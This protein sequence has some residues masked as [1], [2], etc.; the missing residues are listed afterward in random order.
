[1]REFVT[2]CCIFSVKEPGRCIQSGKQLYT[3]GK[4]LYN[5]YYTRGKKLYN[6]YYTRGK[7][8]YNWFFDTLTDLIVI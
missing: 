6:W 3:R 8:L 1:M 5:W 4:T 7:K 2:F